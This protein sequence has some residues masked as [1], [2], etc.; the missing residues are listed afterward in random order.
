M[1]NHIRRAWTFLSDVWLF[2]VVR[3]RGPWY[4]THELFGT[5]VIGNVIRITEREIMRQ[6]WIHAL[7]TR[8]VS[9]KDA[10]CLDLASNEGDWSVFCAEQGARSVLGIEFDRGHI[11]RAELVLRRRYP[12]HAKTITYVEHDILTYP[13]DGFY[14]FVVASG[15]FYHLTREE[16]DRFA[17]L[18]AAHAK[19]AILGTIIYHPGAPPRAL[20]FIQPP[21]RR[22]LRGWP[23]HARRPAKC[24]W[25]LAAVQN[26]GL[27]HA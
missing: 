24:A 2:A 16:Q 7:D 25:S 27:S 3:L 12:R 23:T 26:R 1:L 10:R 8:G 21:Y 22:R 15:I 17:A 18:L 20:R 5:A 14:D 13:Y 19:Y 6:M 4:Q 9:L 11:G